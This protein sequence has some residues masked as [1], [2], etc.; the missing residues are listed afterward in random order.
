MT[1]GIFNWCVVAAFIAGTTVL[2]NLLK[3][4]SSGVDGFFL[5]GRS[6]PWWAVSA[7]IMASQISAVTLIAVPGAIF[8]QGGNLLFLQGTLIGFVI[9]KL[10]MVLLF[11]GPFYETKIYSPY[12]FIEQRLGTGASTLARTLFLMSAIVGHGVRLLTVAIVL[13]VVVSIPVGHSVLLIGTFAMF[14]TLL[15]GIT[16]VIWTDVIQ[17]AVIVTGAVVVLGCILCGLPFGLPEA[18]RELDEAAKLRLLDLALDPAKTWTLWTSLCCFTVFELAQNSVDQVV[19]QRMMCCRNAR[20]AKKAILGSLLIVC[21]T[22][23]M[24]S[25]GLG[26]WLFY[27]HTPL[28]LKDAAF[29]AEQPSRAY[30]FFVVRQLP[31]G[32]SGLAIAA[33][34]AAG[35]S[36][37]A[38]AL[39]ALSETVIHGVY[40][41]RINPGAG[42]QQVL[43]VSRAAVVVWAVVLSL[44]AFGAARVVQNEGLL[45]LAYKVPVLTYGPLLMIALAARFRILWGKLLIAAALGAVFT[46]LLLLVLASRRVLGMDEFWIYPISCLTF[47]AIAVAGRLKQSVCGYGFKEEK[48]SL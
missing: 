42:E 21:F 40:L 38:S 19:T 2:G 31:V 46:S 9:A 20:E 3:G 8:A 43:R 37:L 17:F 25:I 30:P 34:F 27:R 1:F 7:S 29:L 44:L 45:N 11:V 41:K 16:T 24:V 22:L 13:S 4:K 23:L 48:D 12:D 32:V 18:V 33:I 28:S 10:L 26:I 5:G 36:T 35:I 39:S 15:G 6:L 14:W 47:L